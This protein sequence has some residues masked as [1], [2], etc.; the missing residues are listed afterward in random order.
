MKHICEAEFIFYLYNVWVFSHKSLPIPSRCFISVLYYFFISSM[1]CVT[2]IPV[3]KEAS[4]VHWA[5]H[6]KEIMEKALARLL[7]RAWE[8]V[9]VCVRERGHKP[10]PSPYI[11]V[12]FVVGLC[13]DG[14]GCGSFF[15][16]CH[17]Y[18]LPTDVRVV[19]TRPLPTAFLD[20]KPALIVARLCFDWVI[21]HFGLWIISWLF[22]NSPFLSK[23]KLI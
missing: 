22:I 3:G 21:D 4:F 13:Y 23:N 19:F 18:R 20:L 9:T 10:L 6:W 1:K 16:R 17:L 11:L 5:R 14:E 8:G 7:C 2:P 12:K 15:S